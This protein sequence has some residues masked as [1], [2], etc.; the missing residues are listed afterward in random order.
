MVAMF[1]F[2]IRG[3]KVMGGSNGYAMSG[4]IRRGKTPV[5]K[6]YNNGDGGQT[7][8]ELFVKDDVFDTMAA[9]LADRY[10]EIGVNAP[11]RGLASRGFGSAFDILIDDIA[12]LNGFKK[13]AK[14]Y[15]KKKGLSKAFVSI[16]CFRN[17]DFGNAVLLDGLISEEPAG[18]K[19]FHGRGDGDA[20]F[21]GSF[22][23]DEEIDVTGGVVA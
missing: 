3:L 16:G 7:E 2:N 12:S 5:A 20:Y 17:K 15:A 23:S 9:V 10:A 11:S 21:L 8:Y 4:T 22:A 18:K 14:R 13:D 6:F 19:F 1:G